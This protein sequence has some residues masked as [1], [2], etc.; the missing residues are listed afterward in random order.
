MSRNIYIRKKRFITRCYYTRAY[1]D[2]EYPIS[3]LWR[4]TDY[5]RSIYIET[6]NETARGDRYENIVSKKVFVDFCPFPSKISARFQVLDD[7]IPSV[8]RP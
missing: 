4:K 6:R 3:T 1:T 7:S 8:F 5:W 2:V